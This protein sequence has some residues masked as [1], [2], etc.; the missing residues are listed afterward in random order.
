[1][2]S[3]AEHRFKIRY[4]GGLA[5]ENTLPGY[6]GATSID[7]ITRALHIATHAYMTGEVTSRATALKGASI[8]M[9]PARQGS[10]IFELIVIMETFPATSTI[11]AAIGGPMFYDFIKT[12]FKRATGSLDAEPETNSLKRI[13]QRKQPP[14][15]KRPPVDLDELSEILEGSLQDAHRLIG[16]EGTITSMSIG[17]PRNELV[18]FDA[19]T[20]DWVNTQEEAPGLE[21]VR[22]NVTRY[23]SLSRNARVFV[24][25]YGRVVPIR[26]GGDFSIGDLSLLTW[27]LHGSNIGARNKLD[28]RVR[29]ISSASGKIKRL[30]LS[31]CQR[32]PED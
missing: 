22:G 5:D 13:Y 8:H 19:E 27:S 15:L 6:D 23:N 9:K 25:Q 1:M 21:V 12:S 11:A 32:S 14:P 28:M 24:D 4:T 2:V 31:D 7:G 30:L 20:K 26:P 3:L 29:R 10:F 18:I 17:S 16:D